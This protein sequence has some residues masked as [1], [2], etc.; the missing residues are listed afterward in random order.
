VSV[1]QA[2]EA[3]TTGAAYAEFEEG[4]KGAISVGRLADLVVLSGDPF[5]IAPEA[6]AGLHVAMTLVGGK[7]VYERR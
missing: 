5:N 3:Y 1:A 7:V 6:I 4:N 2:L